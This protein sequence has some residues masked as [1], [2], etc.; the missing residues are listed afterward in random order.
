M[1]KEKKPEPTGLEVLVGSDDYRT[2]TLVDIS[3]WLEQ[4]RHCISAVAEVLA[5]QGEA[6]DQHSGQSGALQRGLSG[7]LELNVEELERVSHHL[8]KLRQPSANIEPATVT[9]DKG[10]GGSHGKS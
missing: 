9:F 4:T 7:I 8:A 3:D 5:Y 1:A 2:E 6:A 10:K